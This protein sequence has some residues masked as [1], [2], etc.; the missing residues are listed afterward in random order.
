VLIVAA[1]H[2]VTAPLPGMFYRR[3]D[4]EAEVCAEAGTRVDVGTALGLIE[5][6]KT[7]FPIESD[8]AGTVRRFLIEDGAFVDAGQGLVEIDPT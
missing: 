6:M 3:P 2:T 5:V 8:V 7:F 1:L 4:P